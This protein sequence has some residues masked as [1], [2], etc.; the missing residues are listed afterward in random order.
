MQ[1]RLTPSFCFAAPTAQLGPCYTRMSLAPLRKRLGEHR[2][3][4]TSET[5]NVI[6]KKRAKRKLRN[7][8]IH[9]LAN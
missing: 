1:L 8:A 4:Q 6:R 5:G 3:A 7:S 2:R 9:G